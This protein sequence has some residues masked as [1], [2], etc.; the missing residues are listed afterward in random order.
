M[1]EHQQHATDAVTITRR[2]KHL[3]HQHGTASGALACNLARI[4]FA[5][6][7][8][9]G[10]PY[11]NS[12][13]AC[14]PTARC[15]LEGHAGS[16]IHDLQRQHWWSDLSFCI[17]HTAPGFH[18]CSPIPAC[19]RTCLG[20]SWQRHLQASCDNNTVVVTESMRFAHKLRKGRHLLLRG[21]VTAENF[22][23]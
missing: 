4:W 13:K 10:K 21:K 15:D 6:L 14:H 2:W 11:W 22:W 19:P 5:D 8:A 12:T 9:D 17:H 3:W 18:P 16:Q 20:C 23:I 1:S 7:L